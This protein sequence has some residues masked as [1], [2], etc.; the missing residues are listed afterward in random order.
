MLSVG[1]SFPE[2]SSLSKKK[3]LPCGKYSAHSQL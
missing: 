1:D 3:S 2:L